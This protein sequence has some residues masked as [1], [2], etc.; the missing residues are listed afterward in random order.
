M[1]KKFCEN[2]YMLVVNGVQV[3]R[4]GVASYSECGFEKNEFGLIRS[5]FASLV[6]S[7]SLLV[8]QQ[9]AQ[10]LQEL[11]AAQ[12][13][14]ENMSFDEIVASTMPRWCQSPRQRIEFEQYLIDRKL[15]PLSERVEELERSKAQED[16]ALIAQADSTTE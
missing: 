16:A 11:R 13:N 2:R 10:R 1:N 5:D 7:Q 9:A 15:L 4:L 14:T 3:D 6:N 12:P 8:M